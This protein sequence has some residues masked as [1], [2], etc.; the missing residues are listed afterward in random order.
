MAR[1]DRPGREQ[2]LSRL[3]AG[4]ALTDALRQ[5]AAELLTRAE[6]YRAK[7]KQ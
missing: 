7:L 5:S 1:L 2:E 4:S 6:E 3:M